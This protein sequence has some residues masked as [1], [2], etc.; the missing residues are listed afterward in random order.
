MTTVK[1]QRF[2]ERLARERG[3]P[4]DVD[5]DGL[6][7]KGASAVIDALLAI[8][9]PAPDDMP[10][11]V[12]YASK[13]GLAD[14]PGTCDLCQHPTAPGE[15]YWFGPHYDGGPRFKVAHKVGG[16]STEPVEAPAPLPQAGQVVRASDGSIVK[17]VRSQTGRLYGKVLAGVGAGNR[18]DWTYDSGVIGLCHGAPLVSDDE[19]RA[20]AAV[21]QWG[22]ADP[23]ALAAIAKA[24]AEDHHACMFCGL[25]LTDDPS[26]VAGYGPVCAEKYDLPWG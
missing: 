6:D 19:V 4:L 2:I 1:Q 5:L 21:L 11:V 17:V 26:V 23:V 14:R 12:G 25:E 16:C 20:E 8:A 3:I 22:T 9:V 7:A 10:E 24:H 13:H 15:A 18:L